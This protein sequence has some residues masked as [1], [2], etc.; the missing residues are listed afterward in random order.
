MTLRNWTQCVAQGQI[1]P[2]IWLIEIRRTPAPIIFDKSGDVLPDA[3]FNL[4]G[5]LELFSAYLSSGLL[6][7]QQVF[8]PDRQLSDANA[9]RMIDC[10]GNGRSGAHIAQL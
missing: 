10:V 4:V 9:C 2:Q 3:R 7:R 8:K 1:A 5:H 6:G